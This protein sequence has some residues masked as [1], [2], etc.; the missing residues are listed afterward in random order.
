MPQVIPFPLHTVT[1]TSGVRGLNKHCMEHQSFANS[2]WPNLEHRLYHKLCR[3]FSKGGI[4][5]IKTVV[6]KY[7]YHEYRYS[8]MNNI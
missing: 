2:C 4:N 1:N 7:K 6:G 5:D 3:G 8:M